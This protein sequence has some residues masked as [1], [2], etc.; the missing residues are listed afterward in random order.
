MI[1]P[2][3]IEDD[4]FEK[5]VNRIAS[6]L[7]PDV[8]DSGPEIIDGLER[9]GVFITEDTIHLIECTISRTKAKAVKDVDKLTSLAKKMQKKYPQRAVKG[10][11][12]TREEPTAD[13]R[14]VAKNGYLVNA[15]SFEKFQSK[16]ID[17]AGYKNCRENYPFGSVRDP[18]TGEAKY[19]GEYIEIDLVNIR[20]EKITWNLNKIIESIINRGSVIIQGH[21]GVGKSMALKEIYKIISKK[22]EEKKIFKFPIYLNLRDHHGQTSAVEAIER[23]ARSIGFKHPDHLVRAWR[24]GYTILILDGY[25]EIAA[26]GWTGKTKTLKDI[27]YKSMDLIREFVRENPPNGGLLISGRINYFDSLKECCL[28]F[29]I[30]SSIPVLK[31][32]DF[33]PEQTKTYLEKKKIKI[34]LPEWIPTRP[35]L[36]GY[37]VANGILPEVLSVGGINNSP[38][39]GW[40]FLIDKICTRESAIEAGLSPATVRELIEGI[41]CYAR[42]FQ[43]GLGPLYQSDLEKIFVQKCGYPPDDRAFVVLQRLPGLAPMDQQDGSRYFIDT[44]FATVAKAGEIIKFINNPYDAK[45]SSDPRQWQESLEEIGI[46][47]ICSKFANNNV[48]LIEESLFHA[49]KIEAFVLATDILMCLNYLGVSWTR[50]NIVFKDILVPY[51]EI[52]KEVDWSRVKFSEIIF[53]ELQIEEIPHGSTSPIFEKCIIGKL[54]GCSNASLLPSD[55]FIEPIIDSFEIQETTTSAILSLDMPVSVKVGLTILKKLYLQAG[56]G[57]QENSFYRGL[58]TNEQSYINPL[59]NFFKHEGIAIPSKNANSDKV[60]QPAKSMFGKIRNILINRGYKDKLID[61]MQQIT[62]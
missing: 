19:I 44:Q 53:K 35:L 54:M 28:S 40:D 34:A 5:Q 55:I 14:T 38:A 46:Q 13:Q 36:L 41:A 3:D 29:G 62:L 22:Y 11:F 12:I 20:D 10:W 51:F 58:S 45:L 61:N 23:H 42:K 15:I 27:R 57:R 52:K 50:E 25:D 37:L 32:G 48:G 39:E 47:L 26:F 1:D 49:K 18:K 60:W 24:A 43:N 30:S 59:L 17:V 16:I 21:Y 4:H 31:I 7:W 56:T 2:L 6:H 33:T 8:I 9:D